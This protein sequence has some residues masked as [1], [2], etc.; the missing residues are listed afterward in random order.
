VPDGP[1]APRDAEASSSTARYTLERLAARR[2][3]RAAVALARLP[4]GVTAA[5]EAWRAPL[6]LDDP[7]PPA[8]RHLREPHLR[9]AHLAALPRTDATAPGIRLTADRWRTQL[10]GRRPDVVLLDEV[11]PWLDATVLGELRTLTDAPVVATAEVAARIGRGRLDLVVDDADPDGVGAPCVD[12]RVDSPVGTPLD[13]TGVVRWA[14]G[15]PLPSDVPGAVAVDEVGGDDRAALAGALRLAARGTVVVAV[16]DGRVAR[17]LGS[18]AVTAP[19]GDLLTT[20][21]ALVADPDA[22]ERASIRQRRHVLA[23]H[24]LDDRGRQLLAAAGVRLRPSPRCSVLLATRRPDQVA[25]ALAA[26]VGQRFEDLEVQLLLHGFAVDATQLEARGRR[27]QVHQAV[28]AELPLGAVLD[29][30]LDA[31]SGELVAKMDDDDLYGAGHLAD[32]AVALR[33]SGAD[34]VGRWANLTHLVDRDVTV[35]PHRDRQ[36]RWAH[37]LPGATM[38]V[39][40]SVMR[41]LRWRHVPNGVDRQLIEALHADGGRAYSTHRFGFVRRRHGDHT[42][43]KGDRAFAREGAASPGLDPSLLDV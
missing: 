9:V 19:A 29:V 17:T 43:A 24:T 38:L 28:P 25:P 31:A 3:V 18:T 16:A 20:A 42:F 15:D 12:H 14:P 33:Y 35:D 7:G 30:G 4:R 40:G 32:L 37:H 23:H 21:E 34:V 8:G 26:V 39:H 2:T 22:R 1:A 6:T 36:E 27:L 10:E 5:R 13:P 11:V 41:R